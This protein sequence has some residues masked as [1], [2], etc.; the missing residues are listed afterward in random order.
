MHFPF[1]SRFE[2]LSLL[3]PSRIA[4][5]SKALTIEKI[6][7]AASAMPKRLARARQAIRIEAGAAPTRSS[8]RRFHIVWQLGQNDAQQ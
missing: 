6:G 2:Q 1:S 8:L 7:R 3:P 4:D 5:C